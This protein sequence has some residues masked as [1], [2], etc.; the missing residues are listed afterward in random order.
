MYNRV[1]GKIRGQSI[2]S[3]LPNVCEFERRSRSSRRQSAKYSG[4]DPCTRTIERR[5]TCA[6]PDRH[7]HDE[8]TTDDC[9]S[10][11]SPRPAR[12]R[13]HF[14]HDPKFFRHDTLRYGVKSTPPT[15]ESVVMVRCAAIISVSLFS[16]HNPAQRGH[17]DFTVFAT[18]PRLS[19]R[20]HPW[21]LRLWFL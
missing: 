3:K 16:G 20:M 12:H 18:F 13:I 21:A 10:C 7:Q 15:R 2:P 5:R 14:R 1:R 6:E 8:A 19:R 17:C 9:R 11:L 4:E